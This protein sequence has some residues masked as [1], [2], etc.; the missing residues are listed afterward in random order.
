MPVTDT[1]AEALF[2]TEPEIVEESIEISE[3]LVALPLPGEEDA[4]A[5]ESEVE[6]S[7]PEGLEPASE[8]T[9]VEMESAASAGVEP[10]AGPSG[11]AGADRARTQQQRL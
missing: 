5:E 11:T 4:E 1:K 6:E 10:E 7:E 2:E 9:E 3:T 8:E